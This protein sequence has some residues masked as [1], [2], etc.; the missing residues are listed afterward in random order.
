MSSL[1]N[2][3]RNELTKL[4]YDDGFNIDTVVNALRNHDINDI[5]EEDIK[6]Y[7]SN[8]EGISKK[9]GNDS[10]F[11]GAAIQIDTADGTEIYYIARGTEMDLDSPEDIVYDGVGV[12]TG[13]ADDQLVDAELFYEAVENS[14]KTNLNE[15][16]INNIERYGDG[17]SLGGHLIISLALQKKNFQDVRGQ[18]DAPVNLK[19]LIFFDEDFFNYLSIEVSIDDVTNIP[20]EDLELLARDFY[21][22]EAKVISHTRVRGEPLYAQTIPNT[23]YIGNDI[24]YIGDSNS[25]EFPNVFDSSTTGPGFFDPLRGSLGIFFDLG[26]GIKTKADSYMYDAHI[27]RVMGLI[28]A[29]GEEMTVAEITEIIETAQSNPYA[30]IQLI[31]D[32]ELARLVSTLGMSHLMEGLMVL[33]N[34]AVWEKARDIVVHMDQMD[35][36]SIQS[37]IDLYNDPNVQKVTYRLEPGTT[38]HIRLDIATL[39]GGMRALEGALEEKREALGKLYQYRQF[40]MHERFFEERERI[41][42]MMS[43]KESNWQAFLSEVGFNWNK[44]TIHKPVGVTFRK[45]FDPIHPAAV[46]NVDWIIET[47]EHEITELESM[48]SDYKETMHVLFETDEEL[49]ALIR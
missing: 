24:Y 28:G 18:N 44:D 27:G 38:N 43:D 49:A 32:D 31:P 23:L 48:L 36:H 39:F 42:S 25:P 3:I 46:E 10:G 22:D 15:E 40:E 7:T 41:E 6:I 26:I 16:E 4:Q 5:A 14:V 19:Q 17:H 47:Y 20:P 1:D 21:A 9:I 34:T 8:G 35:L 37:L 12:A 33:S 29:M 30:A 2:H 45:E 11:D 13:V